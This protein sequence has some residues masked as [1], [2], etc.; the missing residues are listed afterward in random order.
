MFWSPFIFAPQE[1]YRGGGMMINLPDPKLHICCT[2][3]GLLGDCYPLPHLQVF[4]INPTENIDE[5]K[6]SVGNYRAD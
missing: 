4:Y 6:S 5:K 3:I 1:L 2:E